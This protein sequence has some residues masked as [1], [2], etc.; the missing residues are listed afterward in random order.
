MLAC[1]SRRRS[2]VQVPSRAL[3]WH[4]TP[5]L[6]ERPSSNLGGCGLDSL[7]CHSQT[8]TRVGWAS[9][10]PTGCKPVVQTDPGGSTPSRRT[11]TR[12]F[13]ARCDDGL[14]ARLSISPT[15]VRFPSASLF[16]LAVMLVLQS[17]PEPGR[18]DP[19]IRARSVPGSI[20]VQVTGCGQVVEFGRHATLRRSC[21]RGRASSSLALATGQNDC[22]WA[23]A[24]PALMRP[25]CPDRYRDLQLAGGPV[26]IR[27][28]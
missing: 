19:G 2:R 17:G 14:A 9:A 23:G 22:R 25:A 3:S 4:G 28:S 11:D 27:A 26:L 16:W 15:R 24:Q 20:P 10:G 6:A 12:R 18:T 13:T 1:L 8:T 21:P 5:S 7:P